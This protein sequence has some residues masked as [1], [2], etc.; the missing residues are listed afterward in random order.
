V[1]RADLAE[2]AGDEVEGLVPG[3]LLEPARGVLAHRSPQPIGVVVDVGDRDPLRAD[4]PL[5]ED[6]VLVGTHGEDAVVL[7]LELEPARRLTERAGGKHRLRHR[8]LRFSAPSP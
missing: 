2:A 6:V 7:D 8:D 1:P 5:R 4:V 3:D